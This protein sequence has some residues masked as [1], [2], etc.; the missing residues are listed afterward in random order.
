MGIFLSSTL[1]KLVDQPK[2]KVVTIHLLT[3]KVVKSKQSKSIS[4][5]WHLRFYHLLC[6]VAIK[7]LINDSN[8]SPEIVSVT[9]K[10][11]HCNI[12][13]HARMFVS[14]NQ[15]A[16]SSGINRRKRPAKKF[17]ACIFP[18]G[19]CWLRQEQL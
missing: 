7:I 14:T 10:S 1:Q 15:N 4:M 3:Q 5:N 6:I 19:H 11:A 9:H 17:I 18:Q 8:Q 2:R 13:M 16:F 12:P